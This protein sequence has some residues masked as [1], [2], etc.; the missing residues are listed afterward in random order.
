MKPLLPPPLRAMRPHQWAKNLFILVPLIT[1]QLFTQKAF[2]SVTWGFAAFC[3]AASAGYIVND[4]IDAPHDRQNPAKRTRPIA[5]GELGV[6]TAIALASALLTASALTALKLGN[7]FFG[8]ILAGYLA[9][10]IAYSAFLKRYFFIDVLTLTTLYSIRIVAG[11]VAIDVELSLWLAAFSVTTFLGLA[12]L[13]RY[14]ELEEHVRRT[15]GA[16][17]PSGRPYDSRAM[18]TVSLAGHGFGYGSVVVL[19]FYLSSANVARLYQRQPLL[20]ILPPLLFWW[21]RRVWKLAREGKM[22][23]DPVAFAIRDWRSWLIAALA[24]A[25]L[26]AARSGPGGAG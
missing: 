24:L 25:V 20:W 19:A 10:S 14:V 11:A 22:H 16:E 7:S 2:I 21:V 3:L 18:G 15:G 6:P 9:L 17:G 8:L 26:L 5:S 4:L 1:S 12:L 13:K 23:H